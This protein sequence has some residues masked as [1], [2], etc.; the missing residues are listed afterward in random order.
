MENS[1]AADIME[2]YTLNTI[3]FYLTDDCN[4][5]CR[6]CWIAP[7]Y[8]PNTVSSSSLSYE[9]FCSIITQAKP[10][11]LKTIKLTGGEPLLHP[12]INDILDFTIKESIRLTIETNGILCTKEI[13]KKIAQS[14]WSHVSVSLD[15]TD[16]K[17]HEWVR[18]VDG[19]YNKTITGIKNLVDAGVK[20]QIIMTIMRHNVEQVGPM[21]KLAESLGAYSVKFNVLQPT[22]RGK[23]MTESGEALSIEE[24][25]KIGEWVESDLSLTSNIKVYFDH[26]PAFRPLKNMFGNKGNGCGTC[27]I[28][29]I[30]GV[31]P[32]GSYA[33]CG[34]GE[35]L[36]EFVFGNA[37]Q[38]KLE[39]VWN[40]SPMI[41]DLRKYIPANLEGVCSK[42]LMKN[43]CLGSCI[44]QN[45]YRSKNLWAPFWYC[46]EAMKK[47]IFPT[48][49]LSSTEI[50]SDRF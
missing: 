6:H 13:A 1:I 21:I 2:N 42:C 22:A 7:K 46:E 35:S 24:L 10:L 29:G 20:P 28:K 31:L 26:P 38:D 39:Q 43:I 34:I 15:G 16:A 41:Q 49:R 14:K 3:Y 44:A 9:L 8:S 17:T 40:Y 37:S 5:R 32:D 11:G 27:G 33:M 4:L 47:G 23:R 18:G 19:C 30:I 36:P 45:Y 50:E 12:R 48:Q 25:I